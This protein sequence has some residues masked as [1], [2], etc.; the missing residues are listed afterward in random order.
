MRN[1]M[2]LIKT[3]YLQLLIRKQKMTTQGKRF[4]K[5]RQ[6]LEKTQQELAEITGIA[7][8][9]ISKVEGDNGY[10]D[11][12][13]YPELVKIL[14][15]NLNYLIAG[16]GAMFIKDTQA[17]TD[18]ALEL[19]GRMENIPATELADIKRRLEALENK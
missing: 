3:N 1:K 6:Q 14:D 17:A 8:T 12:E 18:E 16:I 9:S 15:I 7:R 5:I 2:S 4:K 10:F 13:I 19:V 11:M